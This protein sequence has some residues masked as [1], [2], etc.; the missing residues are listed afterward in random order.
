MDID[1][2][3]STKLSSKFA[4]YRGHM[5]QHTSF[6]QPVYV[7]IVQLLVAH[8][9]RRSR[10]MHLHLLLEWEAK[11]LL[12]SIKC[13]FHYSPVDAVVF[14]DEESSFGAGIT[15]LADHAVPICWGRSGR[16]EGGQVNDWNASEVTSTGGRDA[17][18]N[19]LGEHKLSVRHTGS[20]RR[21]LG[22]HCRRHCA[23]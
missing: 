6:R 2:L 20:A 15:N 21:G 16:H 1:S 22:A 11:E 12:E 9:A 13:C 4:I 5:N 10:L 3:R 23:M 8:V 7:G 19:A 14:D 18:G 17:T